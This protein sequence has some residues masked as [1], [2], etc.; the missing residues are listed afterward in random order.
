MLFIRGMI[1]NRRMETH[2]NLDELIEKIRREMPLLTAA[3]HVQS[4]GVF[5]SR[6]RN[7]NRPDS[8]LDILVSFSES[9]GFFKFVEMENYLSEQL[10]VKVDLVSRKSL[11]RRIEKQILEE[12]I[13]V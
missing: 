10:G 9:P 2:T 3:F 6:V 7:Q 5:G 13:P 4:L 11:R 8:D 1:I 12:L